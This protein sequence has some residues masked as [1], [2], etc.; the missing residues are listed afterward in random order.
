[1]PTPLSLCNILDYLFT[2]EDRCAPRNQPPRSLTE[3]RIFVPIRSSCPS[4]HPARIGRTAD[5]SLQCSP[6]PL[7]S[8]WHVTASNIVPLHATRAAWWY[9]RNI[10][11]NPV[12]ARAQPVA[13]SSPTKRVLVPLVPHSLCALRA[14]E[15][16]SSFSGFAR[17]VVAIPSLRRQ[18]YSFLFVPHSTVHHA[19]DPVSLF[20]GIIFPPALILNP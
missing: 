15:S 19:L 7:L 8:C 14:S 11:P 6:A 9:L 17:P 4:G 3:E 20:H 16:N 12:T 5:T 2:R 18:D 13:V 1:M 10:T